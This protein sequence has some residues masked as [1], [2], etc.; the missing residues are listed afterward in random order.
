MNWYKFDSIDDFDIWHQNIKEQLGLPKI[1]V[2]SNG[3]QMPDATITNAYT[4]PIIVA[5]D[6]VRVYV[7]DDFI[8]VSFETQKDLADYLDSNSF[9]FLHPITNEVV[10]AQ[11]IANNLWNKLEAKSLKKMPT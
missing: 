3:N 8:G 6:D 10:S 9:I 1:S 2:D 4:L 5:D 7:N 11:N